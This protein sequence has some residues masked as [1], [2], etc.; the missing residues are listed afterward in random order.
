MNLPNLE[1]VIDWYDL[2]PQEEAILRAVWKGG[3][4]PVSNDRII[5]AMFEDDPGGGPSSSVAYLALKVAMSHLRKRLAHS[6]L[7][8]ENAGYRRGFRLV[9]GAN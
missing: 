8:I 2:P 6:G 1:V 5:S 7:R 9:I 3:G 4:T